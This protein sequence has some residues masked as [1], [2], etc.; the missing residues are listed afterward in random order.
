[1]KDSSNRSILEQI[2]GQDTVAVV[3]LP[4]I[5]LSLKN[6]EPQTAVPVS[7]EVQDT[8]GQALYAVGTGNYDEAARLS[9]EVK[10]IKEV[11]KRYNSG[12]ARN[13]TPLRMYNEAVLR[14]AEQGGNTE[15]YITLAL[16][17]GKYAQAAEA[18]E[19]KGEIPRAI[20]ILED[21]TNINRDDS[22]ELYQN[23]ADI[24]RR[25][26]LEDEEVRLIKKF[27]EWLKKKD[28]RL[29]SEAAEHYD[30]CGLHLRAGILYGYLDRPRDIYDAAKCAEKLGRKK[31]AL[32]LYATYAQ[33][34]ETSTTP[35]ETCLAAEVCETKL[36]QPDKAHPLYIRT[37]NL[38]ELRPP[39]NQP[40]IEYALKIAKKIGH[41]RRIDLY[42]TMLQT[43]NYTMPKPSENHRET[44]IIPAPALTH[45][46]RRAMD[47]CTG[48]IRQLFKEEK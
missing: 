47:R 6:T 28:R 34:C 1:M 26:G 31:R 13:Q 17:F 38:I 22:G 8:A 39:F 10:I 48:Y 19:K 33:R 27:S 24:A 16:M 32:E 18:T 21:A 20:K 46:L 40:T 7:E 23:A 43:G 25:N 29:L 12:P 2:A 30:E 45:P 41:Q 36:K 37:L 5:H 4:E 44:G 35:A 11:V 42:E 3:G 14:V 9:L 15:Q